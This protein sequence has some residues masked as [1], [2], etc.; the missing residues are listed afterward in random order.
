[1]A[2][3]QRRERNTI[4]EP[5]AP[6]DHGHGDPRQNVGEHGHGDYRRSVPREDREHAGVDRVRP[7]DCVKS[8]D[9]LQSLQVR[10]LASGDRHRSWGFDLDF[11]VKTNVERIENLHCAFERNAK[12]FVALVPR[13]LRLVNA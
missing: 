3:I 9:Y 2:T 1:M 4:E 8:D 7:G 5:E 13:Y 6:G 12:I 11:G 10:G